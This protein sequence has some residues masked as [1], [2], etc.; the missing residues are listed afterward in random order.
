VLQEA[1]RE[2]ARLVM[3][4]QVIAHGLPSEAL[5]QLIVQLKAVPH[6]RRAYLVRKLTTR[7]PDKPLY[8]LGFVSVSSLWGSSNCYRAKVVQQAIREQAMFRGLTVNL[9]ASAG[10]FTPKLRRVKGSRI[11]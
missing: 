4:D 1:K 2:R 9:G 10:Y 8:V 7:S 5:A 6:L 11:I 3:S